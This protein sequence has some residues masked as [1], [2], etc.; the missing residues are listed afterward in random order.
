MSQ[1]PID[2]IGPAGMAAVIRDMD[3]FQ[4]APRMAAVPTKEVREEVPQPDSV[5]WDRLFDGCRDCGGQFHATDSV[6]CPMRQQDDDG[7]VE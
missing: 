4:W 7:R 5:Y 6:Y 1:K 2:C 3:P